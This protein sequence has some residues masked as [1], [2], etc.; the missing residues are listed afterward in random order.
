MRDYLKDT[1]DY[2]KLKGK[3]SESS[4][5]ASTCD[6]DNI[7]KKRQKDIE[8]SIIPVSAPNK[9]NDITPESFVL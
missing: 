1:G 3:I 4:L 8:R 5:L 7:S 6:N 9:S 2:A